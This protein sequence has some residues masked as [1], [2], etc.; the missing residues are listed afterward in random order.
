MPALRSG[1]N[2]GRRCLVFTFMTGKAACGT[3]ALLMTAYTAAHG[4]DVHGGNGA[5]TG[6]AFYI[7]V[8]MSAM[9]PEHPIGNSIQ[10]HPGDLLL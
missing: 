1:G 4:G 3:S 5:M 7:C 9:A 6:F 2:E 10:R 8:K